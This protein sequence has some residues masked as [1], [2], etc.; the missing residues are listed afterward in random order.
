MSR[1]LDRLTLLATFTRIAERGSISAAARDLGLSQASAS[2]QLSDLEARLGANLIRRTTH[3][4]SL[5]AAGQACLADARRLLA[6][7]EQFEEIH[8]NRDFAKGAL[9]VVAPIALGQTKLA[10]AAVSFQEQHPNIDLSWLL[11][12]EEIRFTETGCDLWLRVGLPKDDSLIVRPLGKIERLLV[13]APALL[14]GQFPESPDGTCGLPCV[15]L[16]PFE[17]T[18]ITLT[19]SSGELAT[20]KAQAA[21]TTNNIFS[22]RLAARNGVGF[23]VMPR[24]FVEEDLASGTLVD[25]LPD[26]RA[27]SLELNAAYLPSKWQPTRLKLFIDHMAVAV[28]QIHGIGTL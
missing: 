23:A 27:P 12:D 7:W 10:Q 26:W 6:G 9:T 24:W 16:S 19:A 21:L 14:A 22:A 3:S 20:V 5:T 28:Q 15:S 4:L 13:A 1:S 2:R 8:K 18:S 25:F 17:G 11:D